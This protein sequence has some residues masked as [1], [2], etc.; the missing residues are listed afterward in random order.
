MHHN[1]HPRE[2]RTAA[3]T[4]HFFFLKKFC[5][6]PLS[7][8]HL[9]IPRSRP[10]C[11]WLRRGRSRSAWV[12]S[13]RAGRTRVHPSL[14]SQP[15]LWYKHNISLYSPTVFSCDSKLG[16]RLILVLLQWKGEGFT[17]F[18]PA[19]HGHPEDPTLDFSTMNRQIWATRGE[20]TDDISTACGEKNLITI[21]CHRN[22]IDMIQ[23]TQHTLH[24]YL[25]SPG[26][27]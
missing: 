18:V 1:F 3:S 6:E 21:C 20:T 15:S 17:G 16:I 5:L 23:Y 25:C 14:P 4:V 9:G 24:N 22:T 11:I 13:G 27:K 19:L 7:G 8:S 12:D 26:S 2:V 10:F